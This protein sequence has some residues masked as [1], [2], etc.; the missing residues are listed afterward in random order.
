LN[1]HHFG[2]MAGLGH[3]YASIGQFDQSV[4]AYR[5]VLQMQP[6]MAGIRQAMAHVQKAARHKK[7]QPHVES[8]K[9]KIAHTPLPA[10]S[11]DS[12]TSTK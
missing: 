7:A 5:C 3:C 4:Q 9:P 6:R 10:K 11:L 2:A 8:T 12:D 1:P